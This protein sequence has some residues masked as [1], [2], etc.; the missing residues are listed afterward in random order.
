MKTSAILGNCNIGQAEIHNFRL[1]ELPHV[2]KDLTSKNKVKIWTLGKDASE[3]IKREYQKTFHQKVGKRAKNI[4]EIMLIGP[5][6]EE[7]IEAFCNKLREMG[8]TPLSY[9]I[10]NDEGHYDVFSGEWIPNKHTH[11]LVDITC[12]DPKKRISVTRKDKKGKTVFGDDG[13]PLKKT[14]PAYARTA[15]FGRNDM[16]KLQDYA[17]EALGLERG[18]PSDAEHLN[19][20]QFKIQECKKDLEKLEDIK[21]T[22]IKEIKNFCSL[23]RDQ[24]KREIEEY[25]RIRAIVLLDEDKYSNKTKY[26][27][28]ENDKVRASLVKALEMHDSHKFIQ[29]ASALYNKL[30]ISVAALNTLI[31]SGEFAYEQVDY[32]RKENEELREKNFKLDVRVSVLERKIQDLQPSLSNQSR[33]KMHL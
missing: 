9:A 2:R 32:Y 7:R 15:K 16:R 4:R 3:R 14:V 28:S 33:N 22:A 18:I 5:A 26:L 21:K 31:K 17:A 8:I 12:W 25:N 13:K 24:C 27:V 19:M 11:I 29:D 20:I 6:T 10:H 30:V 23:L 1:K